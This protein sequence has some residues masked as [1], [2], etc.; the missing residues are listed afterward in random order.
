MRRRLEGLVP[1]LVLAGF[2][3]AAVVV[4]LLLTSAEERSVDALEQ[5]VQTEL[6]A[7]AGIQDERILTSF[8]QSQSFI[9]QLQPFS[10]EVGS[11]EDRAKFAPFEQL[12]A[13]GFYLVDDA[14][15]ITQGVLLDSGAIG[16]HLDWPG[17]D[18]LVVT[19]ADERR[20]VP[21]LTVSDGYTSS[22]PV[23]AFVY[24]VVGGA[25][26][27][28]SGFIVAEQAV[29]VDSNFNKQ[30]AT[31]ER[32]ETGRYYV[33]D[34]SG[35]VIASNDA[36]SLGTVLGGGLA[37]EQLG[38]HRADGELAVLTEMASTGWRVA[39]HQDVSEFEQPL[40]GP[41]EST[42]R[43][44]ILALLGAGLLLTLLLYR[45]LRAAR[46]EQ[47]RLRALAEAQQEFI[48]I[49]SHELRTPVAGVL[50]FLE[51]SLDHWD[52]MEDAERKA[53]VSRAAANARRLQA[54]TRDVIDTQRV[55]AGRLVHV[56]EPLD[57]RREVRIAVDAA[58]EL[59]TDR[60]IDVQLPDEPVQ[61]NGDADRIQQVL[62]NLIDN[63]R[64]NSPAVEPIEL[65]VTRNGTMVEVVV[66]DHGP[67]IAD[68]SLE[69]IFDKFVRGGAD[70]VSGTGLGLYISRQIINAHGGRI[71]AESE[72]GRGATF[73]FVLPEVLLGP[74][75]EAEN[76]QETD[77]STKL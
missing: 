60:T 56:F 11:E 66:T 30:I 77:S 10:M 32:G 27:S 53:A 1:V 15:T 62:A 9:D 16:A 36:S 28:R 4:N 46:A 5:S 21:V 54:M 68:E 51:T 12:V 73:R 24:P 38:V 67:G 7:L 76:P 58:L 42:G 37:G 71:W 6:R 50:G 43:I 23:Y 44:L 49:V 13:N 64:K 61:I 75:N 55:E 57:L 17:F 47:E 8:E 25:G 63:A 65:E 14:G 33:Y 3:V 31:L 72:P 20:P 40:T 18:A 29:S 34:A 74:E 41:L 59:D 26:G 70:T 22:G 69:R 39:F 19:P 2:L 45:R 52:V 48:S 35:V